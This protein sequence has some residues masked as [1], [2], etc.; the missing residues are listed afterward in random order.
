MDDRKCQR[1]LAGVIMSA[2]PPLYKRDPAAYQAHLA[3]GNASQPRKR[4][5]ADVLIR[6]AEG[7]IL[8]VDPDYKPDWDLPGG[9]AEPNESPHDAASRELREELGIDR[10]LN[11]LLCMDYV[12]PHGAWDDSLMFIFDGGVIDADEA[13]RLHPTDDEL[14]A[15]KFCDPS[16]AEQLLRPYFWNRVRAALDALQTGVPAYLQSGH[17]VR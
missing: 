14:N 12:E 11:R 16:E 8:I 15:V 5:G 6:D 2:K 17:P 9:M 4:V 10:Q 3:E 1:Q 13:A 7:R